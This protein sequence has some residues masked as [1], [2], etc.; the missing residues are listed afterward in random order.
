MSQQRPATKPI[1][2]SAVVSIVAGG[3]GLASLCVAIVPIPLTGFVCFPVAA[4][5]G[6]VGI[7]AGVWALRRPRGG[8][9]ATRGLAL[10]GASIGGGT[11]LALLC[12]A[13][14]GAVVFSQIQRLIDTVN[15]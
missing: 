13:A 12:L 9:G 8:E 1:H 10:A 3:L 11:V 4:V 2:R 5:L 6:V 7:A 15:R 14:F